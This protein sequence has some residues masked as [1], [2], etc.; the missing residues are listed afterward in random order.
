MRPDW[1]SSRATRA[2]ALAL[3]LATPTGSLAHANSPNTEVAGIPGILLPA[4]T[5][6]TEPH[7]AVT[8]HL[9][10]CEYWASMAEADKLAAE[11]GEKAAVKEEGEEKK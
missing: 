5:W 4:G 7:N 9:K 3:P 1:T 11:V 8:A 6:L 10:A 2:P